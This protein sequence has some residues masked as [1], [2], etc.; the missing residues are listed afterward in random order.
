MLSCDARFS[1]LR[2]SRSRDV[3]KQIAPG[4]YGSGAIFVVNVVLEIYFESSC[5]EGTRV[6]AKT[7]RKSV[8]YDRLYDAYHYQEIK[9]NSIFI[10]MIHD[11]IEGDLRKHIIDVVKGELVRITYLI[12]KQ[13]LL[14]LRG[15]K[16]FLCQRDEIMGSDMDFYQPVNSGLFSHSVCIVDVGRM[17]RYPYWTAATLFHEI[18]HAF[19][20]RLPGGYDNGYI[21]AA[22]E[23]AKFELILNSTYNIYGSVVDHRG[24][25]GP[26]EFFAEISTAYF[27]VSRFY[28]FVRGELKRWDRYTYRLIRAIW[29]KPEMF[30]GEGE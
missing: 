20:A 30:K 23:K 13:A 8:D 18:A 24:L 1:E 6:M 12:P 22:Y 5:G 2:D 21:V 11:D 7:K 28:P 25:S 29:H 15:T 9:N 14:R 16:V 26:D 3:V 19:H 27:G 17:R 4:F 10:L